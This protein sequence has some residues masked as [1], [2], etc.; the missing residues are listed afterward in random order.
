[1]T[2]IEKIGMI[3]AV[4]LPL[5]NIPLIIRIVQRKSSR[6]ISLA[7]VLGVWT[8]TLLMAPAGF[9]SKD[10]V[11]RLYNI[12]NFFLFSAVMVFV[13]IYRKGNDPRGVNSGGQPLREKV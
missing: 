5:W 3:A 2:V 6:D 12:I 9:V 8:C 13:L 1:M 4:V 10:M 11:W 7:W